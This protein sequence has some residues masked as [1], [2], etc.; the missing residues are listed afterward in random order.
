MHTAGHDP[1]STTAAGDAQ[2]TGHTLRPPSAVE[3]SKKEEEAKKKKKKKKKK[4]N[5]K[6]KKKV[7]VPVSRQ[8]AARAHRALDRVR[9]GAAAGQ[10]VVGGA[11]GGTGTHPREQAGVAVRAG[12]RSIGKNK[13]KQKKK[14]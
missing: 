5:K 12:V 11:R 3:K 9:D 7:Q 1:E 13:Q 8:H 2:G 14:L 4:K 6:K 10:I